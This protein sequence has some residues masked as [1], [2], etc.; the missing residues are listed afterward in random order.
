MKW[1]PYKSNFFRQLLCIKTWSDKKHIIMGKL[2]LDYMG[3]MMNG[4]NTRQWQK[5]VN[6]LTSLVVVY[7][8]FAKVSR[9]FGNVY[10]Y[11][12]LVIVPHQEAI[13]FG[14]VFQNVS[15]P[16]HTTNFTHLHH[17]YPRNLQCGATNC[18]CDMY[19]KNGSM[20]LHLENNFCTSV[21]GNACLNLHF[22]DCDLA[23]FT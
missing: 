12:N 13:N 16:E 4:R 10:G 17:L 7:R 23:I 20:V 9:K 18:E 21:V 2:K 14:N 5:Q 15:I 3:Q 11:P 19:W 1:T 22:S 6:F 8:K